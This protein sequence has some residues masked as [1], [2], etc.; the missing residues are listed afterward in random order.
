MPIPTP[1]PGLVISYAKLWDHEHQAGRDE[2]REDRLCAFVLAV[3]RPAS[4]SHKFLPSIA[5][6]R[7]RFPS[8]S[9]AIPD[10]T[11]NVPGESA[12]RVE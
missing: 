4:R 6:A 2:G 9:S 3:E 12:S 7:L 10:S 5:L 11:T 1:E 8:Q